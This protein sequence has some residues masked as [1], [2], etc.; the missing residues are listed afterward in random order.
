M[1]NEWGEALK[2]IEFLYKYYSYLA[3]TSLVPI[4]LW[5]VRLTKGRIKHEREEKKAEVERDKIRDLATT[6][7]LRNSIIAVYNRSI[8]KKFIAIY[9]RDNV[10]LMYQS[11]HNMGGNGTITH[12]VEVL[13]LL[14]TQ[15]VD[16]PSMENIIVSNK[17]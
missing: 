4:L 9:E 10:E 5:V 11:Y 7:L 15:Q 13:R 8:D 2:M 17:A 1:D 16:I 6:A 3:M 12:L 14:P